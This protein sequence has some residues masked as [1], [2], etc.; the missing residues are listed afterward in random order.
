MGLTYDAGDP[1][2]DSPIAPWCE[3][4]DRIGDRIDRLR[5]RTPGASMLGWRA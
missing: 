4:L 1:T 3:D 2:N 5:A